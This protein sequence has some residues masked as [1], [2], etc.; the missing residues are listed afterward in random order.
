M[1]TAV[2]AT[3][4]ALVLLTVIVIVIFRMRTNS[5]K[6]GAHSKMKVRS[7]TSV[8][9]AGDTLKTPSLLRGS[10]NVTHVSSGM[11]APGEHQR[12]RFTAVGV[13]AAAIFAALSAK[14]FGL[15]VLSGSEY[16]EEAESNL[17]TTVKTP[18]PRGVIYD[19]EGIALVRNRQVL[20]VLADA[21]VA[22]NHDTILRLSALLGI[23]YDVVRTRVLDSSSGAQSQRV[24]A[25]DVSLRSAAFISE[26]ADAF[27]GVTTQMRTA[28]IYPYG[29]LAA[30]VLGY[31]G[32]A[33][34]ED[35]ANVP[36]GQDIEMGD[37][38]GKSGVEQTYNSVLAGDHGQRVLITDAAGTVQQVVSETEPAKGSDVCLT[39]SARVQHVADAALKELIDGERGTAASLVCLDVKTGGIIALS[40]YPTYEPEQFIGGISQEVWDA[41]QTEESHY[42]LMNRAI[43]GT[44]PAASCFKAFTGLA[45]LTYGFADAK[46][47]WNCEGTWTGFGEE[48]PQKCWE[49][50]GHGH[51]GL[52]QG[53]VVSCDV[54]FYEIAR[55]FYA[56]RQSIGDE[57]MQDFIKEFGY[58]E[59]T[60]ID[61]AGEARGRI[62]T[63]GWK[64][65]YFRDVPEEAQWLPGDISNMVIGQ[66]YVLVTPLQVAR[67]YA[68]V[69]TGKLVKP[70]LLKEVRNSQGE[71]AITAEVVEQSTPDVDEANYQIMRDALHG[72][73]T[74]NA[75]VAGDFSKLG[76]SAAAKTGTA[77]VAGKQDY[78]WFACYAPYEDPRFALAVCIEEGGSGGSVAS[79]VA[80]RVMKAAMDY[81]EGKLKHK[82]E[83]IKPGKEE[84]EKEDDEESNQ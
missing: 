7:I 77:E 30:H 55:E 26:H 70:H 32:A 40:N 29:A 61:L 24:I 41:Y 62:P 60:G 19:D 82:V 23:P 79:P 84:E 1:L 34:D 57:A 36:E 69:A 65:E 35:L 75:D 83:V 17:Y 59:T 78:A 72:V 18:A 25:Q 68:A 71:V 14:L 64:A 22:E 6:V 52:R 53:V 66:G 39:L 80:A 8:G 81:S 11:S 42:P 20:T 21:E 27:P 50:S 37:V 58:S 15:Q 9:V 38:V 63:P 2:L 5:T 46:K 67:S 12:S 10:G 49:H 13:I 4:A 33:S 74:E 48:Y 73:A 47:E 43:A 16:R 3:I 31:T 54:V 44:Y 51:L 76:F 28:R 45:G 56:A